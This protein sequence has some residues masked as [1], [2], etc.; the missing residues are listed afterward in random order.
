MLAA[1]IRTYG[2]EEWTDCPFDIKAEANGEVQLVCSL[3]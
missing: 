3:E 1:T 2:I